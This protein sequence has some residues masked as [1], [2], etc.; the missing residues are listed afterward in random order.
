[1]LRI[2]VAMT[3]SAALAP[4]D[5][6]RPIPAPTARKKDRTPFAN[7]RLLYE[8]SS[9]RISVLTKENVE[10]LVITPEISGGAQIYNH[11]PYLMYVVL[12]GH[13][14]FDVEI[15]SSAALSTKIVEQSDNFLRVRLE[16]AI[17]VSTAPTSGVV[18]FSFYQK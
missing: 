9:H 11:G 3:E 15:A 4:A 18:S 14:Q 12:N 7:V 13:W 1:M 16:K 17:M 2:V 6:Q 5:V 8:A 10:N